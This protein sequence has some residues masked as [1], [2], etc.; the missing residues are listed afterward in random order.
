[1][2]S[3]PKGYYTILGISTSASNND[4][5]KAFRE[6]A[7]QM[8]PDKNKDR[9]TTKE[10]QFLTEA[11]EVLTDSNNRARYDSSSVS[12]IKSNNEPIK[13]FSC[14]KATAQPRYIIFYEVKSFIFT[15]TR[16]ITQGIFCADC[17]QKKVMKPTL[18]TWILGWWGFPFGIIYTIQALAIN[19]VGG[20]KPKDINA[21]ILSYQAWY[22]AEQG[23][24]DIANSL[25]NDALKF[26]TKQKQ[27]DNLNNFKNE[28]FKHNGK[29]EFKKLKEKWKFPSSSFLIQL[30]MILVATISI[31]ATIVVISYQSKEKTK[32]QNERMAKEAWIESEIERVYIANHPE[33]ELP[34]NG[35]VFKIL[36]N[37]EISAPFQI[38]TQGQEHHFIKM[39]DFN[40]G[41]TILKIFVR[42]RQKIEI[43][44]P[45]GNYKMK[46]AMGYK[47]YG[48]KD[49]F[50]RD[51]IYSQSDKNM[52][53]KIKGNKVLGRTVELFLQKN[54][55]L[56]TETISSKEF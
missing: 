48:E 35:K 37:K 40:T 9:N 43:S 14:E 3:D 38:I 19:L 11:Y 55:N 26:S 50:G 49:L 25:A 17:A 7:H 52:I 22:F 10:F 4:I 44:I 15:T 39:E 5:K 53:F 47:W 45:L 31:M 2:T 29:K 23:K 13:C 12:E 30:I 28:I 33:K 36:K 21:D 24:F 46:Y 18:I 54:G 8:H 34:D 41:K 51:T 32:L 6:K 56:R 27:K 20:K 1:M 42:A 16:N